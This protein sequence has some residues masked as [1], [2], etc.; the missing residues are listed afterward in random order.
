[1]TRAK[2]DHRRSKPLNARQSAFVAEYLGDVT[3]NATRAYIAAG[4]MA[5]GNAAEVSASQ[6]LS[7]PQVSAEIARLEADHLERIHQRAGVCL[8]NTLVS[9]V[10]S[11]TY[12]P[13]K[14]FHADGTTKD[15][16]E[17]DDDIAHAVEGI[18][19]VGFGEGASKVR[20]VKYKL[21]RRSSAQDMLMKHLGGYKADNDSKGEGVADTLGALLGSMRRSA[22]PVAQ[23]VDDDELV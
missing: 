11:A 9:I 17:L 1:M 12:D 15:I 20:K 18:E 3:R 21:A 16:S 19:V 14:L 6:L 2:N 5:R 22:L 4:Y 10:R 7:H 13:R 23:R 8:E